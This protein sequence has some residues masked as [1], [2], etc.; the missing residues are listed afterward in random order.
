MA[1][2]SLE[3]AHEKISSLETDLTKT[4]EEMPSFNEEKRKSSI[5]SELRSKDFKI[6]F[7]I[8]DKTTSNNWFAHHK[9]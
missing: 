3:N 6:I 5:L 4:R 2:I 7:D 8:S 9:L 1:E